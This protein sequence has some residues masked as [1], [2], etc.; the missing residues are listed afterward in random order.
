LSAVLLLIILIFATQAREPKKLDDK[1]FTFKPEPA[2][3]TV[4]VR[5]SRGWF[6]KSLFELAFLLLALRSGLVGFGESWWVAVCV[7]CYE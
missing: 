7:V 4:S 1:V 5:L 2:D 3:P 6:C